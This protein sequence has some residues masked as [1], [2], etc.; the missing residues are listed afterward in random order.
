MSYFLYSCSECHLENSLLGNISVKKQ[1]SMERI[2]KTENPKSKKKSKVKKKKKS[3]NSALLEK[4]VE[5]QFDNKT[6]ESTIDST[7]NVTDTLHQ[8]ERSK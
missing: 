6:E 1:K 7:V 5:N 8:D 2:S 4:K 3:K